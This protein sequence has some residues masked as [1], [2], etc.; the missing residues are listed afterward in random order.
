[1]PQKSFLWSW[2][3]NFQKFHPRKP[4]KFTVKTP[5]KLINTKTPKSHKKLHILTVTNQVSTSTTIIINQKTYL[6]KSIVTESHHFHTDQ[7]KRTKHTEKKLSNVMQGRGEIMSSIH[8]VPFS[9]DMNH[10]FSNKKSFFTGK[11]KKLKNW[12]KLISF[13]A[14]ILIFFVGGK[15]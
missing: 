14:L 15:K 4:Q 9:S 8:V 10:T 12:K 11:S 13:V 5:K 3:I 1:M 2:K 7:P 6:I